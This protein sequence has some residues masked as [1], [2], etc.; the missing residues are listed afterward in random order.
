MASGGLIT[1]Y[2]SFGA[3]APTT[4]PSVAP[5]SGEYAFYQ[6]TT[7]GA[8][9][10]WGLNGTP[11]WVALGGGGSPSLQLD[12]EASTDLLSAVSISASVALDVT[13]D[14][15][16]SK[17]AAGSLLEI[18]VA[19]FVRIIPVSL[20]GIFAQIVLDSGGTPLTKKI[21]GVAAADGNAL[22]GVAPYWLSGIASGSHT[23]K[24]QVVSDANGTAYCRA[25]TM[26]EETLR[27]QV[28][29]HP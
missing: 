5:S 13:T 17:T 29:E 12:Y 25:S 1:D 26:A 7:T 14:H 4:A 3:G 11:A 21:S 9:Y 27:I 23:V 20:N 10:I 15:T 8:L 19:G 28:I 22:T 2:L 6:N 24:I 16:F 18:V